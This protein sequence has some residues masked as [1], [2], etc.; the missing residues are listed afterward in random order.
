MGEER[1]KIKMDGC[2]QIE[3]NEWEWMYEQAEQL[4]I[5][6]TGYNAELIKERY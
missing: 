6:S 5:D 3:V 1:G 4:V 2:R